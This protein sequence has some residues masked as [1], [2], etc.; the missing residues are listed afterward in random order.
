MAA[1]ASVTPSIQAAGEN[2]PFPQSITYPYG[3][4][5]NSITQAEMNSDLLSK[6]NQWR[7]LYIT[8]NGC[9][10]GEKR[11]YCYP[12]YAN[13]ETI[14]EGQG[15]GMVLSVYMANPDNTAK[16]DFDALY[17]YVQRY[18]LSDCGLMSWQISADGLT[19]NTWAAPDGDIDI[20]FSL[21]MA[22]RQW[23]SNG[24]INYLAEAVTYINNIMTYA[25]NKTNWNVSN[26][27]FASTSVKNVCS[28]Q[29]PYAFK[30]F[31]DVTGD[32]RW[33]NV[34]NAA[35][36]MFGYF[37]TLNPDTGLV[38]N[39]CKM[40]D[41][42]DYGDGNY[43]FGYD[44]CRIPWRVAV[45]YLWNG[46]LAST[47]AKNLPL[48]NTTW[49]NSASGGD[50]SKNYAEYKL[51]GMKNV[52]YASPGTT[53]SPM[54]VAAMVD[55][56][57]QSWL[58]TLYTYISGLPISYTWPSGYYGDSVRVMSLL[59]ITG[60][61]PDMWNMNPAP[62]PPPILPNLALNKPV[63]CSSFKSG[64]EALN[65][66]DGNGGTRWQSNSSD[67]Q[68]LQVDLGSVT[69]VQSVRL[70]WETAYGKAYEI[71]VSN[72][73]TNWTTVFSTTAGDGG[74]D[75]ITFAPTNARYVRMYGT[76]RGTRY[77]YSLW[78]IEVY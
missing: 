16:E 77:G 23:G 10:P 48:R 59:T 25:V 58:N 29:I 27:Q 33:L 8:S 2:Y 36:S 41:Y 47:L 1:F 11:V 62:P 9:Q 18:R 19:A 45:D 20:A 15:Y 26:A 22:H 46:T 70:S 6:Y 43:K 69:Q 24:Q 21:A 68:W 28:Y 12:T 75:S 14:S 73:A 67:P 31:Y 72:D 60:N 34:I 74:L 53:V 52:R 65:A 63:T 71:Q 78:E 56:S 30:I 55:S 57:Q 35:Y 64:Y 13:G 51:N 42:S 17:R 40:P 76:V 44:A 61:F 32:D 3:I 4:K 5:P 37:Q 54:T 49:F 66:V 38:P 39:V 7:Q 50:P